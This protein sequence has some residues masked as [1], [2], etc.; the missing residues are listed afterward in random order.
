MQW[1]LNTNLYLPVYVI[2]GKA[3]VAKSETLPISYSDHG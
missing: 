2:T 1:Y 3:L